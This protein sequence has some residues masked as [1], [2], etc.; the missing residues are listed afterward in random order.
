MK[1]YKLTVNGQPRN[2]QVAE[3]ICNFND[4][5]TG[6]DLTQLS[7]NKYSVLIG[8]D[9]HAIHIEPKGNGKYMA[10][11]SGASLDIHFIDPRA[12][13]R[14]AVDVVTGGKHIVKAVM[15]GKVLNVYV[16][17]ED[18]VQRNQGLLVVEAMKMQNELSAPFDGRITAVRVQDGDTVAAGDTLIVI[19]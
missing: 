16:K 13:P 17:Q 18:Q 4:R 1:S 5:E 9:Q 6:F 8:N 14:D 7:K 12:L 15:S 2:I 10:T 11:V 19:E 3:G